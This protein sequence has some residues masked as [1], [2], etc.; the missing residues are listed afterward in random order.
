MDFAGEHLIPEIHV[1]VAAVAA[2]EF[3]SETFNKSRVVWFA[4][5]NIQIYCVCE[6]GEMRRNK[7]GF[8]KLGHGKSGD[9]FVFAEVNNNSFTEALHFDKV[10]KLLNE[11]F[12][13]FSIPDCVRI[14]V[15]N[16]EAGGDSPDFF[17]FSFFR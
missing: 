5:E 6:V 8:N 4:A 12:D 7:G 10:A 14:T 3:H 15:V 1:N 16:V 11:S 13:S 2:E 9:F 17:L